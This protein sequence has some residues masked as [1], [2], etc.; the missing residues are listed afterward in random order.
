MVSLFHFLCF[1]TAVFYFEKSHY[2]LLVCLFTPLYYS[3]I[4]ITLSQKMRRWWCWFQILTM[5]RSLG[6]DNNFSDPTNGREIMQNIIIYISVRLISE[7]IARAKFFN[8]IIYSFTTDMYLL[9]SLYQ[10]FLFYIQTL[11]YKNTS[12]SC[13]HNDDK[14][15]THML[16]KL[17][18]IP[19]SKTYGEQS[20]QK[21]EYKLQYKYA[22]RLNSSKIFCLV[23]PV[24]NFHFLPQETA[25]TEWYCHT[26]EKKNS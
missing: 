14:Y 10:Y 26:F 7:K 18:K 3:S 12:I 16:F 6:F 4:E 23:N 13:D 9:S 11:F 22:S 20:K 21:V 5:I 2:V 19:D 24:S 1:S 17:L 8:V 15:F 25:E